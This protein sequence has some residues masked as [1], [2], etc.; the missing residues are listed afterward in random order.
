M[1]D[2]WNPT[3]YERFRRERAQPFHDLLALVEPRPG[4]LAVD[5]GCGTGDMTLLLHEKLQP[6]ETLG[7]DRSASMLAKAPRADGLRF[8]E[9][10]IVSFEGGPFDLIFSNAALHWLPDHPS[11][12]RR[13]RSMLAPGGQ[14]AVQMPFN[15]GEPTHETAREL[16][17]SHEF[18]PLLGGF[19]A[20]DKLLEPSQY[21]AWLHSLGFVRQHVRVQVYAH[22][23]DDRMQVV[24]W[25]R[26]ALLTD[27]QKRLSEPAF[28]HFLQR[29]TE[30]LIPQLADDRPYLFLQP[31]LLF[32]GSLT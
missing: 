26:G 24:E 6:R 3:Q 28:A 19:S 12:L 15:D 27:Y 21:A 22:L 8:L 31:R 18:K 10:D 4:M 29:F 2:S 14:L 30:L 1:A 16:A 13:L 17:R 20:R 5:L 9:A 23:L 7:V 25:V 32:W 11:L